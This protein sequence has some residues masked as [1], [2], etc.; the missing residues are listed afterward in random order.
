MTTSKFIVFGKPSIGQDE[1]QSIKKVI[2]SKWVGTGPITKKFEDLFKKYKN[3]KNAVAL[4]SCTAALHLSLIACGVKKGDEVITTPMTFASTINSIIHSGAKPVLADIE[5]D[6]FNIDP[7]QI[8]K[9]ITKKTKALIVVHFA[10]LPCKMN[11]IKK[12][13]NKHNIKLIED[14]AHA[15]ETKYDGKHTGNFGDVGCFSF[16]STK[17]LTTVEGGMITTNNKKISNLASTMRIHGLSKDAW[18]RDLQVKERKNYY[19]HYDVKEVG[20]KYNMPDLNAAIGIVQLRKLE[21]NLQKRKNIFKY[22]QKRLDNL[23][24]K[25]QSIYSYKLK[26]AFHL[27]LIVIQKS[28]TSKT[29]D[30]LASYLLKKKIGVGINYRSVTDMY[31]YKRKYRWK[32]SLTKNAKYV[33]DNVISL[34]LYP[35]LKKKEIDYICDKIRDFFVH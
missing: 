4:N 20:F 25:F 26:H 30:E 28:K 31:V 8:I 22:Y 24:I 21:K 29:R 23:P 5:P 14:C 10:G 32:D 16:Y 17:N 15:I 13:A 2:Q 19:R 7:N 3:S 33:G 12:I 9:K 34:P 11:E 35:E 6:T 27:C 1:L 18:K